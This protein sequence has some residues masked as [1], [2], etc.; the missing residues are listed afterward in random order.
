[1]LRN[2][3][4]EEIQEFLEGNENVA[5]ELEAGMEQA[6]LLP[7]RMIL[8]PDDVIVGEANRTCEVVKLIN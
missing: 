5:V 6:M 3:T 8:A 2:L 1:M 7:F 4:P